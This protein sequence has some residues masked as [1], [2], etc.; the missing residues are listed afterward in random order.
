MPS[1]IAGF[2]LSPHQERVWGLLQNADGRVYRAQCAIG[3][4]GPAA[5]KDLK[6]ALAK[7]IERNE[8]LRT[9]YVR[10]QGLKSPFQVIAEEC[11][12]EWRELDLCDLASNVQE[13]YLKE[14][15]ES[16]K[17]RNFDLEHGPIVHALLAGLTTDRRVLI[18]FLPAITVDA[19]SLDNIV[20]ELGHCYESVVTGRLLQDET[21]RY[22]QFSEWQNELRE[23]DDENTALGKDF[24]RKLDLSSV[25]QAQLPFGS[26][27]AAGPFTPE[28]ISAALD[29]SLLPSLQARANEFG[30]TFEHILLSAWMTTIWR[31]AGQESFQTR[32][33]V[34]GR[35][36]DELRQAIGLFSRDLPLR[37]NFEGQ[38]SFHELVEHLS[39]ALKDEIEWQDYFEQD[40]DVDGN[41]AIS[42]E[43]HWTSAQQ[44][45]QVTFSVVRQYACLAPFLLKLVCRTNGPALA[46]ELHYDGSRFARSDVERLA[47]YYKTLLAAAVAAPE[48][49]IAK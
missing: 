16:E 32:A 25:A 34:H 38:L 37:W 33:Q 35:E 41:N 48:T 20:G 26:R 43:Y 23:T 3:I 39:D 44:A 18:L 29:T 10:P 5:S 31:M 22:V 4:D 14:I 1:S 40:Q 6:K 17:C 24:W 28:V 7:V 11:A 49:A 27:D 9:V 21:T 8:V 19:E 13:H 46:L 42:F 2:R 36:Y 45:A 12:L 47:G 30:A 15:F